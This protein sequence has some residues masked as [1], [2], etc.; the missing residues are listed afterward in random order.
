VALALGD[1][2][3]AEKII[4]SVPEY[5]PFDLKYSEVEPVDWETCQLVLDANEKKRIL[6][7]GW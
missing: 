5:H 1:K 6:M 7:Q 3:R 4:D 2:E